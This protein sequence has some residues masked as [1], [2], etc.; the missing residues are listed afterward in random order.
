VPSRKPANDPASSG[1]KG[2]NLELASKGHGR[3]SAEAYQGAAIVEVEHP[4]QAL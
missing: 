2:T 3:N 1:N 4:K